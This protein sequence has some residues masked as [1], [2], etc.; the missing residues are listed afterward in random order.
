MASLTFAQDT[1][2]EEK[3][4]EIIR[5]NPE[6][7]MEAI[8]ILQ[9]KDAK[10]KQEQV[11]QNIKSNKQRLEDDK[12]APILGNPTGEIIIV[13]FFDYNC[14]YCRRAFKTVMN[15]I[16]DNEAI[17]VVLREWPILGDGS[18]FAAKASLASQNQQKYKAFH[19]A[20]MGN[21]GPHTE[22]SVLKIAKKIGMDI[23]QLK[24]DMNSS[25]VLEHLEESQKLSQSLGISG[26][27]VFVFGEKMVPGAID[28]QAMK[29]LVAQMVSK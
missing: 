23:D 5:N 19:K 8:K 24:S 13:E 27:P 20:L 1:D 12:N 29:D 16:E 15:L 2:L 14:G 25:S 10:N 6:I 22:K 18:V 9:A 11:D 4:L 21:R 28:F 7:V 26:T 3:V 17:K